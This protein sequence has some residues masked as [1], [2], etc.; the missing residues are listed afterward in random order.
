MLS[1]PSR[2]VVGLAAVLT[3]AACS[4]APPPDGPD[5]PGGPGGRGGPPPMGPQIFISPFGEP[6]VS[7]EGTKGGLADWFAAADADHDGALT[8]EEFAHDGRRWFAT[9][10]L[11]G[12]GVVGPTE[13]AAYERRIDEA[14]T[15]LGARG[16]GPD[17]RRPDGR[18]PKREGADGGPPR[19]GGMT[20]NLG[21]PQS[22]PPPGGGAGGGA[23]GAP[24]GR[25][26][27]GPSGSTERMAQVGLLRVPQ[28]V[29]AADRN[30]DQTV[31]PEEW[32]A[33]TT[34]WFS[35]L[36]ADHDGVLRLET[37]STLL[38]DQG[39]RG[40]PGER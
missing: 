3:L 24:R 37:L 16:R 34:R 13:I 36:D 18:A 26:G 28:P 11:D 20:A 19:G 38:P 6:F 21:E 4:S 39:P 15:G 9:L 31:T 17:G 14:F 32:A 12:D 25:G 27:R 5:G 7:T 33:T 29:R 8:S 1:S 23:G 2:Q 35:L 22:G 10:D 40:R 30:V